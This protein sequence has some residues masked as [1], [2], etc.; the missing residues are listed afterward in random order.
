MK[1]TNVFLSVALV[2]IM[3]LTACGGQSSPSTAQA[4]AGEAKVEDKATEAETTT[5]TENTATAEETAT[6]D[7]VLRIALDQDIETLD[8]QQNT[9]DYTASVAEGTTEALLR[10][11]NGEYLPG[12]AASYSTDDYITWTFVI[13]DD[14]C[15]S[16]GTPITAQDFEY[17][18]KTIFHRDEASK[19]TLFFEGLKNYP[20]VKAAVKE[21]KKGDDL[22]AVTDTLGVTAKDDRTLVVELEGARPWYLTNFSSTY[23][24]PIKK[25]IFEANGI[26]YGSSKDLMA[27][28]GPFMVEDWKYN[29]SVRLVKNPNYWNKD[30]IK[31]D[32]VELYIVKDVEPRVNMFRE[33]KVDVAKASSEYYQTMADQVFSEEGS[34][35]RYILTNQSRRNAD[36]QVV[37]K[38]IS[39]LLANRDF[40]SALSYAIDR[41]VLYSQV[42][43]DPTI[44]A[45]AQVVPGH[46]PLNNAAS[47]T[48]DAGRKR[49]GYTS[50]FSVTADEAKAK[51]YL[52]KAMDTLG[53]ADASQ[54]PTITLVCASNT[55]VVTICDFIRLSCEETLGIKIEVEPVEFNVRDSRIIS[56]DY[57]LLIMGWGLDYADA[58]SIY[59]VFSSNLFATGWPEANHDQYNTFVE[60]MDNIAA[61]TDFDKRAELLLKA[62]DHLLKYG[63]FITLNFSG[64]ATLKNSRVNNLGIRDMGAR[65]DYTFVTVK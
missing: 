36:G 18:W 37:N 14:A 5:T 39:D 44:F 33:G 29:E 41:T 42:I 16:D 11:H 34:S 63:P 60:Y 23:F 12:M 20:A 43:V 13:R 24:A 57:D 25:D 17:S 50:P 3:M 65:H 51:E 7:N 2:L 38:A 48:F 53:Y 21:G 54:I 58:T 28:N 40:I 31:L 30:N 32:A 47:E 52:K 45:T 46:T 55:D 56:G 27:Y 9:A 64:Y 19:V 10:E 6:S 1:R 49:G 26:K 4:P 61:E 15:W 22:K 59:E 62:E 35:W 8:S